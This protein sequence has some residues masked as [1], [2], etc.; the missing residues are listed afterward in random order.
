M[1][2][3][4]CMITQIYDGRNA[5]EFSFGVGDSILCIGASGNDIL[6]LLFCP[7]LLNLL[8]ATKAIK[9]FTVESGHAIIVYLSIEN[10]TSTSWVWRQVV[11]Q[12]DHLNHTGPVFF[13][14]LLSI[15]ILTDLHPCK[16]DKMIFYVKLFGNHLLIV[17][18]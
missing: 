7:N 18:E 9:S 1:P 16:R 5:T 2:L 4:N 17:L 8:F 15:F 14:S 3:A 12:E 6:V 10:H 13:C 11:C